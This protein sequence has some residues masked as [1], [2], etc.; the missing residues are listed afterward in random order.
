[1]KSGGEYESRHVL[2]LKK[3]CEKYI[4]N[5]RFICLSDV[6]IAGCTTLKL[7]HPSWR[8]WWSKIELF[9]PLLENVPTMFFDL[10]T[11]IIDDISDILSA[12]SGK[13]FVILRDIYRGKFNAKSMQSSVMY[14]SVK[15]TEVYEK[16][17]GNSD[18]IISSMRG[19]QDFLEASIERKV[20]YFQDITLGFS[21]YKRDIVRRGILPK[22]KV[23]V[24]HGKPRPWQQD[25]IP[26][27][28]K[29]NR[30]DLVLRNGFVVP[31]S[32]TKC[33]PAT[34]KHL[35]D[36]NAYVAL[37]TN[38]R[39]VIQAGGNVGVWPHQLSKSFIKVITFEP[40]KLNFEALSIN[41]GDL[42]NVQCYQKALGASA[43]RA[44]LQRVSDNIG[45]HS[46]KSGDEF[47]V[48]DID[49]LGVKDCDLLQLDVEGY[50]HEALIGARATIETSRPLIVLELKRHG[51]RY[52][53]T[54]ESTIELLKQWG[55]EQ[56]AKLNRDYVFK[57]NEKKPKAVQ[58][59][60]M[61]SF[62]PI[63]RDETCLL[64]GNGPSAALDGNGARVDS[65]DQVV[66]FNQFK[67]K[68]FED[69][70]G[71]KTTLWSTFG[72]GMVPHDDIRP[73]RAIFIHG[74]NGDPAWAM[75]ELWRIP[76]S[77]FN[78]IIPEWEN[79]KGQNGN[80]L[81]PSSGFLVASW[82]LDQGVKQ[83]HLLGFDHF[84]K[85]RSGQH[86]YWNS[87]SYKRPKEH[88]G[89]FESLIFKKWEQEG[90]VVYFK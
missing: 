12:V 76:L 34:L 22:D 28:C 87:R 8:G 13:E 74:D 67:I 25:T 47:D 73:D 57:Y 7:Q 32:D 56:I 83:I 37:C 53:H 17:I 14:W 5:S 2:M 64:V 54:N 19:D 15:P 27:E 26:Y 70:V 35:N 66:R 71:T 21:S 49:S 48:I 88:D 31:V 65:F 30:D 40:D 29:R 46:I 9:G 61:P 51:E 11:I 62:S 10:D 59:Y 42:G 50:E 33:L 1:M 86:H 84:E 4:P 78:Q 58:F 81:L 6:D 72:R 69:C 24:F 80:R 75:K 20:E 44:S 89:D 43:G 77:Y 68:G 60:N 55:Y 23:I 3:M 39:T 45:A 63:H 82:L 52:G 79:A 90:R 85:Q 36:L 18:S 41:V 16:F 38:K